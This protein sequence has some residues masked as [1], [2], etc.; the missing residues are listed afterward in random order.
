LKDA[1]SNEVQSYVEAFEDERV[2]K[3]AALEAAET[4]ILR[5]KAEIRRYETQEGNSSGIG[6]SVGG[7]H[8]FYEGEILDAVLD[9]LRASI[10]RVTRDGRRHHIL[11]SILASNPISQKRVENRERIKE[12]LR[13]Y[14][15]MDAKTRKDLE[16]IGFSISD[17]GKHHK[18]LYQNDA[19]Y[20]FTLAKS[21]SDYRGGL[22][23]AG[24]LCRLLF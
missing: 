23:A 2:A 11:D 22:N 4:E 21:G 12:L 24:D 20:T 6:L 14:Q 16:Q 15:S 19:R 9:A 17:S 8:D 1:G 5:L 18:L 7:E 3:S 10:D 13:G